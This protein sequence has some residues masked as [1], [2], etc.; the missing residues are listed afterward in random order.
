MQINSPAS[1]PTVPGGTIREGKLNSKILLVGKDGS[2]NN[3]R[4]TLETAEESWSTPAHMHNMDQV[5]VAIAGEVD[6]GRSARVPVGTVAYFPE[7]VSYGPQVRPDKSVTLTI[8][9]GGASGNGYI[10]KTDRMRAQEELEKV[11]KFEQGMYH[12]TN[13]SGL[14]QHKEAWAACWEYLRGKKTEYDPPRYSSP[15]VMNP[16]HFSWITDPRQKGIARKLLGSFHER[17]LRVSYIRI[18]LG[19]ALSLGAHSAPQILF[20]TKGRV[21][22]RGADYGLHTAFGLDNNDVI[23]G[24]TGTEES[25]LLHVQFPVFEYQDIAQAPRAAA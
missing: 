10:S 19:A 24:L 18:G 15:I 13:E 11:G 9:L 20:V 17:E 14:V 23:D 2:P 3:Y 1:V 5:R 12:F 22:Y 7:S 25:E 16:D 8:Q 6:Y 4:A 21:S